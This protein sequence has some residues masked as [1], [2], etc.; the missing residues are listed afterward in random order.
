MEAK[1]E[2][3]DIDKKF[4]K[5][6]KHL[7]RGIILILLGVGMLVYMFFID[8]PVKEYSKDLFYM[9]T[10]ISI[11]VFSKNKTTAKKALEE[12]DNI[13]KNYHQLTSRYDDYNIKNIYYINNKLDVNKK[14]EIDEDLYEIIKYGIAVYDNTDGLV[15][16][17][18]GNAIDVWNKYKEIGTSVPSYEEL[19]TSGSINIK[20]IIL[21]KDNMIEKT[22]DVK[23]DLGALAKGYVTDIVGE[24]LES[25]G[26]D[27]YI[28]NAGGNVK[29]GNHYDNK[30]YRIG[31]EKPIKD[32]M[33][34]YKVVKGNN[35]SVVTSGSYERFY[36]VND[37][38]YHHIIDP[39]T[40]F[41]PLNM[42]SVTIITASSKLADTLSTQLFLMTIEEGMDYI[43]KLGDVE[44]VWYG[45]DDEIYYS[46]GFSKYE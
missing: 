46:K 43:N 18:I 4:R 30:E 35:V 10:Y 6:Y 17:A 13:Y 22:S 39:N 12:V 45:I 15:N 28:I 1:V 37:K 41:P 11:Q 31:L 25:L 29:V 23:L 19:S 9:D 7:F 16:I 14:I 36:N 5:Y 3:I 21:H 42:Y 26:I 33:D 24:Y 44:A 40:L 2:V 20:D 27:K 34:I 38:I 8:S 32:S